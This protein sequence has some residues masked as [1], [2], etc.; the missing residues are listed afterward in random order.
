MFSYSTIL[1]QRLLCVFA[2]GVLIPPTASAQLARRNDALALTRELRATAP[3]NR[4]SASPLPGAPL[5]SESG[6]AS[7]LP[8]V[9]NG[10]AAEVMV[11]FAAPNGGAA[12]RDLL[13]HVTAALA[14]FDASEFGWELRGDAIWAGGGAVAGAAEF[15]FP[16]TAFGS[17]GQGRSLASLQALLQA[18]ATRRFEYD[19]RLALDRDAAVGLALR[20]HLPGVITIPWLGPAY[21]KQYPSISLFGRGT[22][23]D[24]VRSRRG[25]ELL[26]HVAVMIPVPILRFN[27]FG[28]AYGYEHLW[29]FADTTGL[30]RHWV[31]L[32]VAKSQN[33]PVR[34]T[35]RWGFERLGTASLLNQFTLALHTRSVAF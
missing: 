17:I 21:I 13:A 24:S 35:V 7:Q 6:S 9:I 10:L 16:A 29:K 31:G 30:S 32:T 33:A 14:S 20:L 19:S 1:Q 15:R 5:P 27:T 3:R 8:K 12:S 11:P 18:A 34:A 26:P 25:A 28:I 4:D 23:D 22:W 2:L